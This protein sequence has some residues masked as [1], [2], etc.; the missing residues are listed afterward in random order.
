[1]ASREEAR[2]RAFDYARTVALSDGV[3]SIA[4]TLLVLSIS[5]PTSSHELGRQLWDN[6]DDV[7]S[8]VISFAVIAQLW[9]HHH[10]FFRDVHRIDNRLTGLNLLY[11]G[12]VAF[13]PYPTGVLGRYGGHATAGVLL[14]AVT[15][16]VGSFVSDAMRRHAVRN[17]LLARPLERGQPAIVQVVFLVS[18]P[19]AFVSPVAA[20]LSWLLL[21]VRRFRGGG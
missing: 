2:D 19:I 5:P 1:V 6:A 21:I 4:M 10:R 3:F 13:L 18:I 15:V 16:L 17:G 11:L 7:L 8:Y 20:M 12:I 14:Y 9:V